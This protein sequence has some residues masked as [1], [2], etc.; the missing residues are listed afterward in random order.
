MGYLRATRRPFALRARA[1][2]LPA[3]LARAAAIGSA[4]IVPVGVTSQDCL[5]H[6]LSPALAIEGGSY[7]RPRRQRVWPFVGEDVMEAPGVHGRTASSEA[8]SHNRSAI[9]PR[10]LSRRLHTH[11]TFLVLCSFTG[12]L[13]HL[14]ALRWSSFSASRLGDATGRRR[15]GSIYV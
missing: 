15:P 13:P 4:A 3:R 5:P 10:F 9:A 2:T 12:S 8:I 6:S 14:P 7:R 1:I 11:V